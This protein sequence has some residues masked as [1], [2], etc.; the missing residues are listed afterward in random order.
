[1]YIPCKYVVA[2]KEEEDANC[3]EY[4]IDDGTA[5]LLLFGRTRLRKLDIVPDIVGFRVGILCRER[6]GRGECIVDSERAAV[7][8]LAQA[9]L[10]A[11][12]HVRAVTSCCCDCEWSER[13]IS[14]H[15]LLDSEFP[16]SITPRYW[17]LGLSSYSI[18]PE[19]S[20]LSQTGIFREKVQIPPQNCCWN[21]NGCSD[22]H[23]RGLDGLV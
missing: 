6:H 20:A 11:T 23:Q 8:T 13:Y 2:A 7:Y 19:R 16:V 3:W 18:C 14:F 12:G 10:C 9:C 21:Q 1:M 4:F 15:I 22:S 5:R 17:W